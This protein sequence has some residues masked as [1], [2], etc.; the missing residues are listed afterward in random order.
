MQNQ[1]IQDALN[2][3][4][5]ILK[6]T[7]VE[8]KN[9]VQ[10]LASIQ[11]VAIATEFLKSLTNDEVNILA[12]KTDTEKKMIMEQFAKAHTAD[13]DFKSR[14]SAAARDVLNEHFA[15]LKTRGDDSQKTEISKILSE[16]A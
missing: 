14:A 6:F 10:D 9:A 4:Y 3:V 11:Q 1:Q 7:E 12:Q 13:E 2:R 5:L 8:A 16:L 15:Y